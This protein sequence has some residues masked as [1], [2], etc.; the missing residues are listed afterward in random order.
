MRRLP[1]RG[2][3]VENR[4]ARVMLYKKSS[5]FVRFLTI[6]LIVGHFYFKYTIAGCS[7]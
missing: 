2:G 4:C 7:Y 3:E 6:L 1:A 5:D